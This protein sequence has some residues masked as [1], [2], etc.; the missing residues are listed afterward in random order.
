VIHF[1]EPK[2]NPVD[3]HSIDDVYLRRRQP[4]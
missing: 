1:N 3:A 2:L 4:F